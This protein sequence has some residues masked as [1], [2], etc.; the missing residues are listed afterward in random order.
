MLDLTIYAM[1]TVTGKTYA[2]KDILS[3]LNF[4]YRDNVPGTDTKGWFKKVQSVQLPEYVN[5][6]RILSNVPGVKVEVKY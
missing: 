4:V 5:A 6:I 3:S 2:C 1:I